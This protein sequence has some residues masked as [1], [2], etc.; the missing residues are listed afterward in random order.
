[1]A[2]AGLEPATYCL[3]GSRS[4]HLSYGAEL[5]SLIYQALRE[6]GSDG[7]TSPSC[8]PSFYGGKPERSSASGIRKTWGMGSLLLT[9]IPPPARLSA[10]LYA[11]R[12]AADRC[13]PSSRR[14]TR[15]VVI[16]PDCLPIT[17]SATTTPAAG[18]LARRMGEAYGGSILRRFVAVVARRLRQEPDASFL[19]LSRGG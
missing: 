5:H 6:R 17:C 11:P 4:I 7:S 3:E 18:Y 9:R 12:N 13:V 8:Q 19:T 2:P 14:R 15:R 1:M 10:R 16:D